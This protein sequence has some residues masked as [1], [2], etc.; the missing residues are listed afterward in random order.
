MPPSDPTR[1]DPPELVAAL[2]AAG[3]RA[4][5]RGLTW[6]TSGNLSAR[7]G[8]GF[9]ISASGACLDELGPGTLAACRL[10]GDG[11][12]GPRPSVEAGMHR[13]VY[14]SRPD[15]GAI[16]H[17]S[18]PY[19]TLV[20]SSELEIDT[21][22]TTDTSHYVRRVA[23]VGFHVPGTAGLAEAAAAAAADCDVLLLANHGALVLAPDP[24]AA[25]HRT[26]VLELLCRMLVARAQGFPLRPLDDEQADRLARGLGSGPA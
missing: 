6:G 1:P 12:D 24:V 11:W 20:A 26:E 19:A 25:V 3:R 23:R 14:R 9:L 4:I 22:A 2:A 21:R 16:L 8:A 18:P 5:A 15:A 17:T 7:A 10:A 13:A